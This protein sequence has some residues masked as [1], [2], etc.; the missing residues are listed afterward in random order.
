MVT[1]G[2][3]LLDAY[4]KTETVEHFAQI[5]LAAR[6]LGPLKELPRE[7]VVKLIR[8]RPLYGIREGLAGCGEAD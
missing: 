5:V 2:K 7:E 4:Y 3:N 1:L 6:Q 8:R